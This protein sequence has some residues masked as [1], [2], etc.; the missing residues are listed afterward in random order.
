MKE[1]SKKKKNRGV[2]WSGFCLISWK[3]IY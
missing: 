1:K 2:I 3:F